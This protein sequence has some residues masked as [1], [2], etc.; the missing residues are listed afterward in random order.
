MQWEGREME[1]AS[2]NEKMKKRKDEKYDTVPG[3]EPMCEN[4]E[5]GQ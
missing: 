1:L 3:L 5:G 2:E 4:I